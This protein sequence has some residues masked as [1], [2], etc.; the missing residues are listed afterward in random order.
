MQAIYG[1]VSDN[2]VRANIT[3]IINQIFKMLPYKQY[4]NPMF[5]MHVTTLLFRIRGMSEL[6][7]DNPIWI[8]LLS[9]I[10]AA[11]SETDFKLFRKSIL[12]SCSM[13]SKFQ[14]QLGDD[15]A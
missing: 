5:D 8:T 13:L 1:Y 14:Q 7:P 11:K 9:N 3:D 12:D 10:Q 6:F 4:D 15:N 2:S